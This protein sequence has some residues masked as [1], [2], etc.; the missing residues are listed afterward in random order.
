MTVMSVAEAS[1]KMKLYQWSRD[2]FKKKLGEVG[3]FNV[4]QEV[5]AIGANPRL[6]QGDWLRAKTHDAQTGL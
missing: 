4:C 6:R 2:Y 5:S 3:A 1:A